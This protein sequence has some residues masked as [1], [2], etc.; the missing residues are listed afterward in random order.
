[1][2][3]EPNTPGARN[4]PTLSN[5]VGPGIFFQGFLTNVLNPKVA[6]FRYGRPGML[7]LHPGNVERPR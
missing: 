1:M 7:M 4:D 5:I 3:L 6:L 2:G